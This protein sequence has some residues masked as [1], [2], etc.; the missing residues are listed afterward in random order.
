[1][2]WWLIPVIWLGSVILV[3]LFFAGAN[4]KRIR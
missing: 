4:G 3:C 1:M 2:G